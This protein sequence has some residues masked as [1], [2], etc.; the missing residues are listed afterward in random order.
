V[1]PAAANFAR[2]PAASGPAAQPRS[3]PAVVAGEL[4]SSLL[5]Y[6]RTTFKLQ[7][8]ALEQALF[9]FLE[10]PE[11]GLFRGPYL[12]VRLP[13]VQAPLDWREQV[14]LDYVPGFRP[15]A[16][17]LQAFERLGARGQAPRPTLITTG[18][19]SGKTECFLYPL[20]DHCRRARQ[21]GQRGIKAIVLYPMNALASD[22]AARF[23]QELAAPELAGVSA[24]LYVGGKGRQSIA[25]PDALIDDRE[26]LRKSPPDI[27]LTNYKMLDLLLMR[28]ADAS[29]WRG[30][31]QLRYLVLDEL[32]SYD[33]A[34]GSDVACLIRRLK[35]RLGIGR[36]QLC[37]V[38]TSATLGSGTED[39]RPL[40]LH[41]ASQVFGEDFEL[42]AIIEETRCERSQ[43]LGGERA[44]GADRSQ[45]NEQAERPR[46]DTSLLFERLAELA[47][48]HQPNP[49][50]PALYATPQSYLDAQAELWGGLAVRRPIVL[51][52]DLRE[53][54]FLSSLL[55]ALTAKD[56][57]RGPVPWADVLRG[58][59]EEYPE[60]AA[61]PADWRWSALASFLSLISQA[62]RF[63]EGGA[64]PSSRAPREQPF[65]HVEV[66]LWVREL[67]GLL[68]QVT[69]DAPR[70]TWADELPK[71]EAGEHWLP[72][73]YC[74]ECGSDG[75]A[76]TQR[77]SE[78][79]LRA[80]S[81][82][83]G[84][85]FFEHD[86][87]ARVVVR[88]PEGESEAPLDAV[89]GA[90]A[91]A[92]PAAQR[93]C[94][95]CLRLFSGKACS[96]G[97][98][99]ERA[100]TVQVYASAPQWPLLR[101]P[102]CH[103]RN[104]LT[105]LAS[106]V[107][108]LCSVA[109]SRWYA[110][111]FNPEPKLL[112]FTDSVQD[113][114]H[115]AG[116]FGGRAHRFSLRTALQS[117]IEQQSPLPAA[118]LARALRAFWQEQLGSA[119]AVAAL[120][121]PDLREDPDV[122]GYLQQT[123]RGKVP[124]PTWRAIEERLGFDALFEFSLGVNQGRSLEATGCS[125]L[126]VVP[127][128]LARA[129]A[130]FA[131]V[132]REEALVPT[133]AKG[134]AAEL[135]RL[136]WRYL[137][138]LTQRLRRQCGVLH[139]WLL[140]YARSG[141][142]F[143][144]SRRSNPRISHFS[145]GNPLPV[146]WHLSA[147]H[148][149]H[150]A[151]FASTATWYQDFF[152]RL[153]RVPKDTATGVLLARKAVRCLSDASILAPVP[154][155][156]SVLGLTLESLAF[157]RDCIELSCA[158]CRRQRAVPETLV[159]WVLGTPCDRFRCAGVYAAATAPLVPDYY[160][161]LYRS[162]RLAC[163]HAEEHTGLLDRHKREDLEK[164][165]KQSRR[166]DAP[167]L[168]SCTPT[169]EM[170]IDIGDLGNVMLCS[171]PPRPTNYLQR[172]G[173]AGRK[174]GN[175][176]VVTW[177]NRRPHDLYFFAQ[178]EEMLRG[179]VAPPGCFLDAPEML[180]RQMLAHALDQWATVAAAD[181]L[182][183]EMR[184][185][186]LDKPG[187]FP[188][189]FVDFYGRE[190]QRLTDEF[191]EL[192]ALEMSP[193][194][195]KRLRAS[196]GTLLKRALDAL[197]AA[198]DDAKHYAHELER[199]DQQL[200]RLDAAPDQATVTLSDG[201]SLGDG[202]ARERRELLE[203][204][205]AYG[206]LRMAANQRYPL[207]V[208]TDA[209]VLPNY[210]FPEPGVTLS[211][212]MRDA[213]AASSFPL[214]TDAAPPEHGSVVT[215]DAKARSKGK[216]RARGS[217]VEYL[218]AASQALRDFAP[219][220]TFY[221]EG[222]KI[223]VSQLDLGTRGDA[224]EAWVLCP[225]CH[226]AARALGDGVSAPACPQCGDPGWA[227][228]GQRFTL[229]QFRRALSVVNRSEAATR[230]DSEEREQGR[231]RTEQFIDVGAEHWQG[232]W[233]V[234][235]DALVFGYELLRDL[236]LRE[237]NFGPRSD[238]GIQRQVGGLQMRQQGFLTCRHCGKV[239]QQ[240][241]PF[242]HAPTCGTRTQNWSPKLGRVLLYR[243]LRS[244]A[245]RV[246][247]PVSDY[248]VE[249]IAHSLRAALQLGFRRK[250][251][252]QPLHLQI[253]LADEY[254]NGKKRRFLIIYDTVPGGT[255]YL[256][257]LWKTNGF[258]EVLALA[259]RALQTCSYCLRHGR[260]GCYRCLFA[261]QEQR[262]LPHLS[263]QTAIALLDKVLAAQGALQ[264][265]ETLS[266]ASLDQ[267]LES[268][269]EQRFVEALASI[270]AQPGWQWQ[271]VPR[272]GKPCYALEGPEASWLIEPQRELGARDGVAVACRPDFI[273]T[274]NSD[275]SVLPIAIFCDGLEYHVCPEAAVSRLG[276]DLYK[277]QAILDSGQFHVWSLTWKDL[278]ASLGTKT[279]GIT[280]LFAELDVR[281]SEALLTAA[282]LE[283]PLAL[284]NQDNF[285]LL[286]AFL[287][288][289][290]AAAW[291]TLC[292][293]LGAG[294]LKLHPR[295]YSQASIER[296]RQRL[297]SREALSDRPLSS[298]PAPEAFLAGYEKRAHAALLSE[299]PTHALAGELSE[300]TTFGWTLRLFDTP[301]D[302]RCAS[303]EDSWRAVL[304]A[305]NILQFNPRPPTVLSGELLAQDGHELVQ[306]TLPP[307]APAPG[308]RAPS[309][310]DA[311]PRA[312]NDATQAQ[313]GDGARASFLRHFGEYRG[314]AD[315]LLADGLP[316]PL[317]FGDLEEAL[318]PALDAQLCWP[319]EKIALCSE[320]SERDVE[321]WSAHGW[322]ALDADADPS[323]ILAAV[324]A[325]APR[326]GRLRKTESKPPSA[327]PARAARS[328]K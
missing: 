126:S 58:L 233:L 79:R 96:C 206:R 105:W 143:L 258:L 142:A 308:A 276:D 224:L 218:R 65:L 149:T 17:Q 180:A 97:A 71:D 292:L 192:F 170:G 14:P 47:R 169:L 35:A 147:Q 248:E 177:A 194:N 146:F 68:C 113:A 72:L 107:S 282:G 9:A 294:S 213:Q 210:A 302:R 251:K 62:R 202:I 221:A 208:L 93:L 98:P 82:D 87:S 171:V 24:G 46:D 262:F 22:Q 66:Q 293:A 212:L 49:T 245:I 173:R 284:R 106:R 174:S 268:E 246:L 25:T 42:D 285:G 34:Q 122:V 152:Q 187:S 140:K 32:H 64:E 159:R 161:S 191:L 29:L 220:N 281:Q 269:L 164:R 27:L 223:R 80:S 241:S 5:D 235:S 4:R 279:S 23:A 186:K 38:G 249:R 165:F 36:G 148:D 89:P 124:E 83:V 60:L 199:L 237:L 120:L 145:L 150:D 111:E 188:Q 321:A 76:A 178:P 125:T 255:G 193:D 138:G 100:L 318:P 153:F 175:A 59:S 323:A 305:W 12:D 273:A 167:N 53:H 52:H 2:Q 130:A 75:L 139:P 104:G 263:R 11:R 322:L 189:D 88:R 172:I 99:A 136:A 253:T 90:K 69:P 55:R 229:L 134:P 132:L 109:L 131:E 209:G 214:E 275:P 154:Q 267:V 151:L 182:P 283:A 115:R 50:D 20:L 317:D 1:L 310:V 211:A 324:K 197:A 242:E 3:F 244:E 225:R 257:E 31:E 185:L 18:T 289:P 236:E 85:A 39:P 230:D 295:P 315:A 301:D 37:P 33:G 184:L 118:G 215:A 195:A 227:D 163:I 222:H 200:A 247:L 304:H 101:C 228:A 6:L 254:R 84:R 41:F 309:D 16:H 232:A 272:G 112:A 103:A 160:K 77:V 7:N 260:D 116:F 110:S 217:R 70:F 327:R 48:T 205:G 320:L 287:Q 271:T 8:T 40:L 141:N 133:A 28:P 168:L 102:D 63:D 250:F 203:M 19:G 127:E 44:S 144:L 261:Y 239:S 207:N 231:Y 298:A 94:A 30:G 57:R 264:K 286:R 266:H 270:G 278:P 15:Y 311:E 314:L 92:G 288:K 312:A 277:R 299:I 296:K 117:A 51:G 325:R 10:D 129:A 243:S 183:H 137:E 280:T 181:A 61:L 91:S 26:V 297:R 95:E 162:G 157:T 179:Q 252:G 158:V 204:K 166:A 259:L 234:Q 54:H 201:E 45:R 313:E 265:V 303:F 73:L 240:E 119:G 216:S 219:F 238:T 316:L 121:P 307:T 21:Q 176:L 86:S 300:N 306:P 108:T 43:V 81:G 156:E 198:K 78:A 226:H 74:R 56:R 291:R 128:R 196:S 13:F 135:E 155:A 190:Q 319:A 328:R 256:A 123:K 114:S 67:R 290:D 274:C 326:P